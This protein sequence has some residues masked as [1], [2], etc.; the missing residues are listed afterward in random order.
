MRYP[1]IRL[2]CST[3]LPLVSACTSPTDVACTNIAV[4]A[5]NVVVRDS[6]SGSFGSDGATATAV[7]GSFAD[8]NGLPAG[9]AQPETPISLAHEREGSYAVTV[10][11]TGYKPWTASAVRVTRDRC[12]VR[13]V[14]LNARLQH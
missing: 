8:T 7:D 13:T 12:H 14:T 1:F 11:K 5:I 6:V 10:N 2:S 4:P 3:I 9:Y